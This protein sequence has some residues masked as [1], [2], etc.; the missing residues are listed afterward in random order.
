LI[1]Q[2]SDQANGLNSMNI[3]VSPATF[4]ERPILRNLMELYQ[5]D[6]SELDRSDIGPLGL[7]EYPYLDH[8]WVEPDRSPF[9]VHV[10]GYLAGFVLVMR[11]NYLT[12]LKDA[13]VMAEFFI[14]RKYRHQGLGQHTACLIFD[15]FVG[16]WQVAQITE[17]HAATA[18]WRKVIA[19]YTHDNYQEHNLDNDNWRGPIQTFTAPPLQA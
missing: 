4:E 16:N 1:Y 6:F 8:Y 18:F 15:R 3:E 7:F 10:N 12:A 2:A 9:L 17:N 5:Y 19:R 13:W 11:Y 14:M